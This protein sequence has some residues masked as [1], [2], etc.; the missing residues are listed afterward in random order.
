M[1]AIQRVPNEQDG[2]PSQ[3]FK[4]LL[5]L[6]LFRITLS[7]FR[8]FNLPPLHP[9]SFDRLLHE[10]LSSP[11]PLHE[12]LH[13]PRALRSIR[14]TVVGFER[15]GF[16][17]SEVSWSGKRVGIGGGEATTTTRGRGEEGGGEEVDEKERKEGEERAFDPTR[18]SEEGPRRRARTSMELGRGRKRS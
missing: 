8:P 14:R 2:S 5:L 13:Q 15:I 16:V 7:T 3:P 10:R 1:I 18:E 4:I 12:L 9:S 17:V 6:F 11:R